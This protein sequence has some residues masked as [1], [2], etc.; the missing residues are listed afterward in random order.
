MHRQRI[1]ANDEDQS[2]AILESTL[3]MK[4]YH[5]KDLLAERAKAMRLAKG[6]PEPDAPPVEVYLPPVKKAPKVEPLPLQMVGTPRPPPVIVTPAPAI[7]TRRIVP[8]VTPGKVICVECRHFARGMC[9]NENARH[10]VTGDYAEAARARRYE[11]GCGPRG[12]L[13]D[14]R[15]GYTV[16]IKPRDDSEPME[17]KPP[18]PVR[19]LALFRDEIVAVLY[20]P[21]QLPSPAPFMLHQIES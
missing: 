14:A 18:V 10:P 4:A 13:W 15:P 3:P 21:V 17:Y 6:E 16:T 20:E 1:E 7:T 11:D 8:A 5:W 12:R 9:A 2:N 19:K